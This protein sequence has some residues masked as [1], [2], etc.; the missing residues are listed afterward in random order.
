M[1]ILSGEVVIAPVMSA[2]NE[3][4]AGAIL[5]SGLLLKRYFTGFDESNATRQ[6]P[7][8]PNH[9]IWH[10]GHLSLYM[11][12]SM[13][14]LTGR[15]IEL[16]WDPEPFAFGSEPVDDASAYPPL[17]EMK[18]RLDRAVNELAEAA[19]TCGEEALER[20][21]AWGPVKITGRSLL[22]RM[23][24]HAGTHCGQIVD[25]RRGLGL[26]RVLGG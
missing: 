19:R 21:I 2:E 5:D 4:L 11:H 17:E 6:A 18:R 26:G 14:D 22:W 23:V 9:L 13:E 15:K 25:L 7:A 24:F 20:E 12:R 3:S 1:T 8:M 10:L 16:G